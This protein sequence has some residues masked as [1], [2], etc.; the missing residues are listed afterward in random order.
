MNILI[1]GGTGLI[2]RALVTKLIE[3]GH[4]VTVLTRNP[5]KAK[6]ILHSGSLTKKWDG[7]NTSDW[8][9]IIEQ[10]DVVINLAGASITGE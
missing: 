1:T 8:A 4:E 10:T 5:E 6:T 9:S 3:D 7:I 2:G